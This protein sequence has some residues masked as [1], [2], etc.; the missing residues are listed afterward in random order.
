MKPVQLEASAAREEYS[1]KSGWKRIAPEMKTVWFVDE[2]YDLGD[3]QEGEKGVFSGT[4]S[5]CFTYLRSVRGCE[6]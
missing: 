6:C 2:I 4:E 3:G 1:K 5:E